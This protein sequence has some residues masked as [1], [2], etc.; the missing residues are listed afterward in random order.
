MAR[1]Y[2]RLLAS[3]DEYE[4]ARLLTQPGFRQRLASEFSGDFSV[5]LHLAPPLFSR[6][7]PR[8]GR[9]RKRRYGAWV[10]PLLRLL[11]GARRL[12]GSFLDPFR[13]GAE[14]RLE[15][16]LLRRYEATLATLVE[17]LTPEKHALAARIAA[18]PQRIRGFG[19][20]RQAAAERIRAEERELLDRFLKADTSD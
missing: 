18:L 10:F 17:G 5:E 4:V 8:T 6:P 11:A 1:S 3:K 19:A 16:D 7:D 9:P 13:Y 15:R 2:H 14:R 12:R 20:V